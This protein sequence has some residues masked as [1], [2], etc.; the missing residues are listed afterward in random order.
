MPTLAFLN[1]SSPN[2]IMLLYNVNRFVASSLCMYC[3]QKFFI[4]VMAQK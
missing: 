3:Y 1:F 4:V 2:R